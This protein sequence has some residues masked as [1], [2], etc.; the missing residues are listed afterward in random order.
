MGWQIRKGIKIVSAI[1]FGLVFTFGVL[2]LVDG[3]LG[4]H[5]ADT[6]ILSR[7][8][9]SKLMQQC[10]ADAWAIKQESSF[11]NRINTAIMAAAFFEYRTRILEYK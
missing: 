4:S 8:Q 7:E 10:I 2:Y 6:I 5:S 11:S 3:V 1:S 9:Q